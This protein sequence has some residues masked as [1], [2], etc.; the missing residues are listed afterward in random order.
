MPFSR[1]LQELASLEPAFPFI[2]IYLDVQRNGD[3]AEA[4]RIFV[5][6]RLREELALARG[7]REREQ[8]ETEMRRALAFLE[9]V[10]HGRAERGR[11][12]LAVFACEARKL[13]RVIGSDVPFENRLVAADRPHLE[14]LRSA[15]ALPKRL[16]A[17]LVDSRSARI[18]ELGPAS[19]QVQAQ[20]QSDVQRRHHQGGWSQTRFQR[21]IDDQIEHH[22]KEAAAALTHLSDADS[23]LPIVL[24]GP[25]TVVSAFR[26]H[27]PERVCARVIVD[28]PVALKGDERKAIERILQSF[29]RGEEKK[30]LDEVTRRVDEAL[31]PARGVQGLDAVLRTVNERALLQLFL[32][33][34]FGVR[35]WKC[36]GCGALGVEMPSECPYCARP[37][38]HAELRPHLIQGVL[39]GKGDV[40]VLPPGR[41]VKDGI[42]GLL[43]FRA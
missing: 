17:C 26:N 28:L 36:A 20:V 32:A 41:R 8:L 2:S 3:A 34:D 25:E 16:L 10:I 19:V 42:L 1:E 15:A 35:G 22:H 39:E 37:V 13:F 24:A 7:A 5:K 40:A 12:G 29:E 18:L 11:Q 6:S 9:D 21:H 23:R 4:M 30:H 31:A 33:A 43:R 38:T 14:P 27:L